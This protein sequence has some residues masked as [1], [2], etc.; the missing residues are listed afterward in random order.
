[1]LSSPSCFV[2]IGANRESSKAAFAAQRTMASPSGSFASMTPMQPCRRLATW[3]VTKTPWRSAKTPSLGNAS[4]G[5]RWDTASTTAVLASCRAARR[6]ASERNDILGLLASFEHPQAAALLD[7]VVDV[8]P[9]AP[10]ILCGGDQR[11][12]HYE[13]KQNLPQQLEPGVTH[14]GSGDKHRHG[15]NLQNHFGFSKRG[16]FDGESFG[17]GDIAQAE[18]R[19]FPADD[20]HHHPRGNQLH[21]H[22]RNE[23]RG[24]QELVGNGVE[25]NAKSRDLQPAPSQIAIRPIG[26]SR[27]QQ[28]EHAPDLEVHGKSPE[29]EVGA[30]SE[31][32]H[33]EDG[34]EKDPQQRQ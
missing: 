17:R 1:M 8:A 25:K 33:Y 20:D 4:G 13:P 12:D 30:A 18:D 16:G 32:D 2:F 34:N 11:A 5:L 21:A 15:A 31:E 22:Q 7:A 10:E 28:D 23:R 9:E 3:S 27:Q 6:S 14:S 24:N 26:R 19:E 29:L